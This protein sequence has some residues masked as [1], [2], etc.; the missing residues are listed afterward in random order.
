MKKLSKYIILVFFA[1]LPGT[2]IAEQGNL[3]KILSGLKEIPIQYGLNHFKADK[4]EIT[5]I[6]AE[7]P[8]E[9]AGIG[10]VYV[11]FYQS[12]R[13]WNLVQYPNH[14]FSSVAWPHGKEDAISAVHFF[15]EK[16]TKD[17]NL[18]SLYLLTASRKTEKSLY[19]PN[20]V[21]FD[22]YNLKKNNDFDFI[23]FQK[24]NSTETEKKYCN[25]DFAFKTELGIVPATDASVENQ[26]VLH[27]Q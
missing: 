4:E 1:F 26:C 9:S 13:K 23:E 16:K 22:L 14:T 7:L 24:V 5:V 15:S 25:V 10:D 20:V 17:H 6:R 27:S 2:A 3:Q 11:V 19:K 21:T 8:S 12:G 18:E